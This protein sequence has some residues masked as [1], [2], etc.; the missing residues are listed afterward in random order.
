MIEIAFT[1]KF[2]KLVQK[3]ETGVREDVYNAVENLKKQPPL[4]ALKIHPLKGR[5]KGLYSCSINFRYRIIFE[6]I[7]PKKYLCHLVGDHGVYE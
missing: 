3:L 6:K 4:P 2:I 5:M 1:E 7:S